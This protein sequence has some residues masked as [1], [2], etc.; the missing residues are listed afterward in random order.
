[1]ES[2]LGAGPSHRLRPKSPGSNRLRNTRQEYN[3]V[4]SDFYKIKLQ[5]KNNQHMEKVNPFCICTYIGTSVLKKLVKFFS[6]T[7]ERIY[8]V[9]HFNFSV[10]RLGVTYSI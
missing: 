7:S 9:V 8:T 6:N 3:S 2:E 1:M 4:K 5:I 10:R